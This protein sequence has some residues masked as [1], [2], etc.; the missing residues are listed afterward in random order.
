MLHTTL[1]ISSSFVVVLKDNGEIEA[2]SHI[3]SRE[4]E[5]PKKHWKF[6]ITKDDVCTVVDVT[7]YLYNV[8]QERD[9]RI[10]DSQRK[11]Y[12]VFPIPWSYVFRAMK[13]KAYLI[14]MEYVIGKMEKGAKA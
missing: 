13:Q 4:K 11:E 3:L 8:I 12:M 7:A 6:A 2:K 10:L 5:A 9:P 1:A 14:A